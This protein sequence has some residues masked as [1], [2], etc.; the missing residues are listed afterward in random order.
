MLL[1]LRVSALKSRLQATGPGRLALL[2]VPAF[3]RDHLGVNGLVLSTDLL[4]GAD[5]QHLQRV[6]ES[7]D[8]AGCPCLVLT[9]STPQQFADEDDAVVAQATDRSLR[10]AQAAAWLGCSAFA[11]PLLATDDEP[12]M[13][14]AATNLKPVSRRAEKLDLN[15][16]IMPTEGLTGHPE[17]VTDLLKKIG[18]F[19][20]GTLPDFAA[21]AASPDPVLYLRRLVPYASAVLAPAPPTA[22]PARAG[23]GATDPGEVKSDQT[24]HAEQKKSRSRKSSSMPAAA[25]KRRS[26]AKAG[27][28]LAQSGQRVAT[29]VPPRAGT[30]T[31][32]THGGLAAGYDLKKFAQV[33]M[34]VG[35]EGPIALDY[36]GQGDPI[37]A[38]V[39]A[40][41]VI[42]AV[43][44]PVKP[45]AE[46]GGGMAALLAA[47]ANAGSDELSEA[48][49]SEGAEEADPDEDSE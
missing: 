27:D 47:V 38:L 46:A 5:K 8:K 14:T 49:D 45:S 34:A 37:S 3:A 12:S 4:V 29:A 25:T 24:P 19:R 10:V 35:Y 20:V 31:S 18:G 48:D 39:A 22:A 13:V 6:L 11:L 28:E 7:A 44:T 26:K 15:M 21:A 2:D 1:T 40:R 9:E 33:L 41:D 16:C 43:L 32:P 36:R 23:E 42:T 30:P 17:R